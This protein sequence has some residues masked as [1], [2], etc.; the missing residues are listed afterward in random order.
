VMLLALSAVACQPAD[1]DG[2]ITTVVGD[3]AVVTF[4]RPLCTGDIVVIE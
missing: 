3:R 2:R 4:A 1:D